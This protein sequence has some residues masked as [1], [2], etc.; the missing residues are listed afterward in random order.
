MIN[1][2]LTNGVG[3]ITLN[4]PSVHN[5]LTR[6]AMNDIR[7]VLA[8]WA[9]ADIRALVITGT[10]KSFC[11]GVSLGEVA[12]ED[13][14]NNPLTNLCD[15]VEEFHTPTICAL[16]GGVYGGGAE[17]AL[18][19]DFRIGVEGMKMFVPAAKI[20][21]HYD[22]SGIG[23]YVQKLGAQTARRIFFLAE[24]FD[25]QALRDIGFL[26]YLVA[27]AELPDFTNALAEKLAQAAPM[28]VQ[29][30]KRTVLEI[31]R[32]T[33]DAKA[34]EQRI[35]ACFA[36]KDHIEGLAALSEKRAPKFKGC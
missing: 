27:A 32:G 8:D 9:D 15:A 33:L 21:V 10:G 5:S 25:D 36:S 1:A 29:G 11:S 34:A 6:Q 24:T 17:L 2:A 31:S 4:D 16:N 19:C 13:W 35:A 20:G 14:S 18:S 30:M 12:N 3:R 7:S 22:P 23:R 26:D 28:A